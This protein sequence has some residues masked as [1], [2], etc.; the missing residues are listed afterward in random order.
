MG[1]R[2]SLFDD[3][4]ITHFTGS[5]KGFLKKIFSFFFKKRVDKI[6]PAWYTIDA[7]EGETGRSARA[8]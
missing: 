8:C 4:S 3:V 1:S 7:P 5:V 6:G 2:S